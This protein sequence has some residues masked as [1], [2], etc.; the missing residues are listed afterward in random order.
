MAK[1]LIEQVQG[2]DWT[3]FQLNVVL[4]DVDEPDE[5][6]AFV[7]WRPTPDA[8]NLNTNYAFFFR[9]GKANS[10]ASATNGASLRSLSSP[11]ELS[12]SETQRFDAPEA[13]QAVAVDTD[14]FYAIANATIGKYERESGKRVARWRATPEIPL[15]HLNS[16]IIIDG[17]LYCAH[18][19]YPS[20]PETSSIEIWD[21]ETLTHIASQSFGHYEG[22]L[23]WI[24]RHDGH[25]WAVFAHYTREGK[26]KDNRWTTLVKF[27]ERWRRIGGWTFPKSVL[28]RFERNSCSGGFW[29]DDGLLYC[30]GHDH[31]EI[32]RL[33][34]PQSGSTLKH[35]DTVAAPITGQ[36]IARIG[37]TI[38]GISRPKRQVIELAPKP[39]RDAK[40]KLT[41]AAR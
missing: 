11:E 6:Y 10:K 15:K 38:F 1:S 17:K 12:L 37:K 14:H 34:I 31:G 39:S 36:G 18:S 2:E 4:R 7:S 19:N 29:G 28:D 27:D 30:T 5:K 22:S 23:T 3:D 35:V 26:S 16:G 33:A 20:E 41:G 21:P 8:R 24:D 13:V 9:D 40:S 25:W 32:Y